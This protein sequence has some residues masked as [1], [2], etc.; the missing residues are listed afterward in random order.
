MPESQRASIENKEDS[1]LRL[2]NIMDS[3][4]NIANDLGLPI[5]LNREYTAKHLDEVNIDSI[6][7]LFCGLATIKGRYTL[8]VEKETEDS[9]IIRQYKRDKKKSRRRLASVESEGP[10]YV[11]YNTENI[12][13][14]QYSFSCDCKLFWTRNNDGEM[15][16]VY[17][18]ANVQSNNLGGIWGDISS[19]VDL[20]FPEWI[21][22][23][24]SVLVYAINFGIEYRATLSYVGD[25]IPLA[26]S[27]SVV[28]WSFV[29]W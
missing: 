14:G 11:F 13:G 26:M 18:V 21:R 17:S 10:G 8:N 3:V 15:T 6:R 23:T 12:N 5:K 1:L 27:L 29:E 19:N 7:A 28:S 9:C 4:M 2:D 16:N 24:G 25:Y 22:F 20:T